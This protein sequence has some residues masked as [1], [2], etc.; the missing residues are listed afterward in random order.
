MIITKPM[1]FAHVRAT[2][3]AAI[4]IA[5]SM[6]FPLPQLFLKLRAS[7][8]GVFRLNAPV[9]NPVNTF[10]TIRAEGAHFAANGRLRKIG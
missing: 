6:M 1:P 5:R 10:C 4:A 2:Y 3:N 8:L 7:S 9:Y